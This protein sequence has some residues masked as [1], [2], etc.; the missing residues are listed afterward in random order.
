VKSIDLSLDALRTFASNPRTISEER[1]ATLRES[2]RTFGVYSPLV[3]RPSEVAG[4]WD[5]LAG[6]ARLRALLSLR[7]QGEAIET[8]SCVEFEGDAVEAGLLLVRDNQHDG[9]WEWDRLHGFLSGFADEAAGSLALLTG[10]DERTVSDLLALASMNDGRAV[11][12]VDPLVSGTDPSAGPVS[13][14]AIPA[15][16]RERDPEFRPE[17]PPPATT[18]FVLGS[19]RGRIPVTVHGDLLSAFETISRE[20]GSTDV[21]SILDRALDLLETENA[22]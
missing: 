10:F 20:T 21:G 16:V 6:N 2:I 1:L 12:V 13:D 15:P 9:E 8:V 18:R 11:P 17:P 19:I 5:V 3:V 22:R 14:P 4:T 7:E